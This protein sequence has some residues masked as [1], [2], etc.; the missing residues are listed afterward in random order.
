MDALHE[1]NT[2]AS[3]R[4]CLQAHRRHQASWCSPVV[5]VA[6]GISLAAFWLL[7]W[8][9]HTEGGANSHTYRRLAALRRCLAAAA[10]DGPLGGLPVALQRLAGAYGKAHHL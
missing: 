9:A 10:E 6:G 5:A 7:L 8:L 1:P 3:S 2:A 4:P